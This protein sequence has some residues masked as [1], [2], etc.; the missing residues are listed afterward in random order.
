MKKLNVIIAM[1]LF[2]MS[3]NLWASGG[4]PQTVD[5][6]VSEVRVDK[7]Y[8]P[9]IGSQ[10]VLFVTIHC[11]EKVTSDGDG[12]TGSVWA[13]LGTLQQ[14][15]YLKSQGT[16]SRLE[17]DGGYFGMLISID[18]ANVGPLQPTA[19]PD[20]RIGDSSGADQISPEINAENVNIL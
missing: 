19:R 7:P 2:S 8:N 6:K 14:L 12:D 17:I 11:N 4:T 9:V 18:G 1:G 16:V 15:M 20:L 10:D 13:P 3:V 5:C